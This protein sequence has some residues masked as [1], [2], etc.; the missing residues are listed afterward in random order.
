MIV[1][2]QIIGGTVHGIGN[3]M[4]EW[5][6]YDENAQPL[7]ANFGEYLLATAPELPPITVRLV[8]YP[9][10]TNPLGVKGVGEAGCV[11]AAAAVVSA[12]ENAL[13]PFAVRIEEAPMLPAR[14]FALLR[15]SAAAPDRTPP[16]AAPA[17]LK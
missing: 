7:T 4:F 1:E 15:V 10:R 2:G 14:L 11:P 8:E 16:V 5:M 17:S 12:I 6:G 3:A 13:A 9:A